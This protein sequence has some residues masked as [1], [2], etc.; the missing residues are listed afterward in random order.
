MSKY[1]DWINTALN[2]LDRDFC[3]G[4]FLPR[5]EHDITSHLWHCLLSTK[6]QIDGLDINHQLTR[7]YHP[8]GRKY[9]PVD[10]AIIK[11]KD[12]NHYGLRTII[13]I[14]ETST[15]RLSQEKIQFTDRREKCRDG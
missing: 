11:S 7:E 15:N 9:N 14:K 1:E 4:E 12:I 10:L 2:K 13:E 6:Q 8:K 3:N 5:N